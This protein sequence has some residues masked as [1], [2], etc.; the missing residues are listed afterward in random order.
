MPQF[1]RVQL[2]RLLGQ[3]H[4]RDTIVGQTTASWGQ[5]NYSVNIIDF[6][7]ADLAASGQN[8]HAG[9]WLKVP[10]T[11]LELRVASF[12]TGSGAFLAQ[13][14]ALVPGAATFVATPTGM[15]Y[16]LHGAVKPSDKDRAIDEAVKFLRSRREVTIESVDG[17]ADYPLPDAVEQV[18][19]AYSFADPGGSLTRNKT[20]LTSFRVV[21]T[22]TGLEVRISPVLGGSQQLVLD[23]V[24]RATLGASDAAT[25]DVPDERL[26]L[27]RAEAECWGLLAKDAPRGTADEYRRSRDDAARQYAALARNFKVPV[28]RPLRIT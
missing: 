2:R 15:F 10:S 14:V 27:L 22:E 26:V 6:A 9:A 16:E 20:P 21:G 5:V 3:N 17:L 25:I 18:L 4:I 7:Q 19:D 12:N 13:G 28:D 1:S 11:S 8:R 23:A 24:V